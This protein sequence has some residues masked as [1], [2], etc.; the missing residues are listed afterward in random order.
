MAGICVALDF[1]IT[2]RC[3]A[4]CCAWFRR[5]IAWLQP[6]KS[7]KLEVLWDIGTVYVTPLNDLGD[8]TLI[9]HRIRSIASARLWVLLYLTVRVKGNRAVGAIMYRMFVAFEFEQVLCYLV[10]WLLRLSWVAL[11]PSSVRE[12]LLFLI[13]IC[14]TTLWW[15]LETWWGQP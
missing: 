4:S 10:S 1:H 13:L 9:W 7:P 5:R 15:H 12:M 2:L 3:K 14:L 11:L 8:A 6:E